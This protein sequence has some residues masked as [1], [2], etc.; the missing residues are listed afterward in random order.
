[1]VFQG[2][3]SELIHD[4]NIGALIS[5]I[6]CESSFCEHTHNKVLLRLRRLHCGRQCVICLD[7]QETYAQ[8]R[9]TNIMETL[10]PVTR[11]ARSLWSAIYNIY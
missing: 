9:H 2:P 11:I 10:V 1:M 4:N 7:V 5:L 6:R 3:W 8:D